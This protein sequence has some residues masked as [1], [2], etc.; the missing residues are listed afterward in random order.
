MRF[1][2][3]D[4][5]KL[6][7]PLMLG[8][9]LLP[10]AYAQLNNSVFEERYRLQPVDS[11]GLSLRLS[12]LGFLRN[13]EYFQNIIPGY[14]LFG[15][16]VH[17]RLAYQPSGRVL[18]EAGAVVGKDFGNDRFTQ[19]IPTFT[20]KYRKDSLSFL[21]GTLEGNLNHRLIEPLYGFERLIT[22][23]AENGLQ[24]VSHRRRLFLDCWI[25]WQRATYRRADYQEEISG[26]FSI[27][28]TLLERAGFR[29]ELPVQFVAFHRGGQ[30][31]ALRVPTPLTNRMN[32]AV[33]LS[34]LPEPGGRGRR[35]VRSFRLDSYLVFAGNTAPARD[36]PFRLGSGWYTNLTLRTRILDVVASYWLAN[37]FDWSQGGDLYQSVDPELV[38][39]DSLQ[40]RQRR[41]QAQFTARM[42]APVPPDFT[43]GY[44]Y[45]EPIRELLI[46]RL[47]R[48]FRLAPAL[49]LTARLEVVFRPDLDNLDYSQG[50]YLTYR[51]EFPVTQL[52]SR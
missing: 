44:R 1:S 5:R 50:L 8:H 26:G 36:D 41:L 52:R 25:D 47:V 7:G 23:R 48:D 3:V 28:Y 10:A 40:Y 38:Y 13:N 22:R 49:F 39:P 18:L 51:H 6:L 35:G 21:F 16:Q 33:G 15:Q 27:N 2:L 29:L 37:R 11:N 19:L 12:G 20:V 43:V 42:P 24:L 30:G 4:V 46:L 14:T 32:G 31:L 34:I 9:F 45:R 17:V